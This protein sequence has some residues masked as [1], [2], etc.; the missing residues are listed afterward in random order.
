LEEIFK[1]IMEKVKPGTGGT[2]YSEEDLRKMANEMEKNGG[3]MPVPPVKP[4]F[5]NM[6]SSETSPDQQPK[7]DEV[8]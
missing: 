8:D 3:E 6:A 5:N 2:G 7:I 4:D 1:D